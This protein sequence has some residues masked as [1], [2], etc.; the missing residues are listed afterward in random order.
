M[1][2]PRR[3]PVGAVYCIQMSIFRLSPSRL[4]IA[5]LVCAVSCFAL[6]ASAAC[7]Q[8]DQQSGRRSGRQAPEAPAATPGAPAP[9]EKPAAAE[10]SELPPLPPPA[11]VEQTMQ[12]DGKTLSYTVTIGATSVRDET[13][14]IVGK[15]VTTAYTMPGANRPVTFAVNG[16]PGAASVFL[17]FGAIG[18]K[19]VQ[20]GDKGDSASATPT[21]TDN[22]GTWLGFT[23]LVF[24]DPIGT[25]FSR[26]L[27]PDDQAKKLF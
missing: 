19:H 8:A 22:Q 14:K 12:L 18:P 27:V 5:A 13:G 2:Q 24:I 26:S 15:V 10:K 3:Q 1:Q 21:L 17:N 11:H 16:G 23:D 20:F 6:S 7:A 25:G 4:S 9:A